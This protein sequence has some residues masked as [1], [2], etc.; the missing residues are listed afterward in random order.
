MRKITRFIYLN[1]YAI[2]ILICGII[3]ALLPL[4]KVSWWFVIPQAV[5]CLF[6]LKRAVQ[7]FSTWNDKMNKY[8]ILMRRNR[9]D[10]HPNSFKPFMNAPCG[11]LLV[12]AVL[13][14]LGISKRYKELLVFRDPF[15]VSARKNCTPQETSIYINNEDLI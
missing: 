13:H 1:S 2:L 6:C 4:Y 3:A 5:V 11:R 7:L 10:F 15:L 8:D 12:K 14:D 9:N